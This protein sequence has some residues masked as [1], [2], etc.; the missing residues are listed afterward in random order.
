MT[1]QCYTGH[2]K[3]MST[4]CQSELTRITQNGSTV[5]KQQYVTWETSEY[6]QHIH[7]NIFPGGCY[8]NKRVLYTQRCE[9][10]DRA[11]SVIRVATAASAPSSKSR[12]SSYWEV[13]KYDTQLVTYTYDSDIWYF[14]VLISDYSPNI[15]A[16]YCWTKKYIR[17]C[18]NLNV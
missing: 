15:N 13:K 6:E 16:R 8:M 1:I 10:W 12:L 9:T 17:C 3:P 18:E 5:Q 11:A 2:G 14:C 7:P 4:T